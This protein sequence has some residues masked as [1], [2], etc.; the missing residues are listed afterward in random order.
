M[1]DSKIKAQV[2][3]EFALGLV[4]LVVFLLATTRVFVWLANDIT[5]RHKAYEDTRSAVTPSGSIQ[6]PAIDFYDEKTGK[7]DMDI[8][9][10]KNI[11]AK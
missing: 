2:I 9:E 8:F 11:I 4:I 1:G 10:G 3:I 7:K 6:P 5:N